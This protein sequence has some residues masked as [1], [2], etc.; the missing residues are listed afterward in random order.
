MRGTISVVDP[1]GL[2][3]DHRVIVL[4]SATN[5]TLSFGAQWRAASAR[6]STTRPATE[7]PC[8]TRR[9]NQ[10]FVVKAQHDP[11]IERD[12]L[13]SHHHGPHLEELGGRALHH[14]VSAVSASCRSTAPALAVVQVAAARGSQADQSSTVRADVAGHLPGD[15]GIQQISHGDRIRQLQPA[16]CRGTVTG[17]LSVHRSE[18]GD[19]R[20]RPVDTQLLGDRQ[21]HVVFLGRHGKR[22]V[23]RDRSEDARFDLTE[24]SA[25]E[26]MTGLGN[27]G[28]PQQ[29]RHVVQTR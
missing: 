15:I 21:I 18:N 27:D 10:Q 16:K 8:S 28:R 9:V 20:G 22:A 6:Q 11:G 19:L 13:R 5:R 24:V 23:T 2:L 17:R 25:D 29:R 4:T 26:D 12:R 14:R 3:S 7:E 1:Q